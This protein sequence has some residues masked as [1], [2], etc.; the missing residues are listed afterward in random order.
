MGDS[1]DTSQS[2][3]DSS[4]LV[5]P[6]NEVSN[7][8][9]VSEKREVLVASLAI[10]RIFRATRELRRRRLRELQGQSLSDVAAGS[11]VDNHSKG[12]CA[13]DVKSID[14]TC[15]KRR[16]K[17]PAVNLG[18]LVEC[19]WLAEGKE[20][21]KQRFGMYLVLILLYYLLIAM[22][23]VPSDVYSTRQAHL[24]LVESV[25]TTSGSSVYDVTTYEDIGD[26][27]GSF[28]ERTYVSYYDQQNEDID[29]DIAIELDFYSFFCHN[30]WRADYL[31]SSK[32]IPSTYWEHLKYLY[33]EHGLNITESQYD[34]STPE[35]KE[36][37]ALELYNEIVYVND[38]WVQILESF[39][40]YRC[41]YGYNSRADDVSG[42]LLSYNRVLG[43]LIVYQER[44]QK[45]DGCGSEYDELYPECYANA[46]S[47]EPFYGFIS[48]QTYDWME[49]YGGGY[50]WGFNLDYLVMDS[51]RQI[52]E[53]EFVLLDGWLHR[54]TKVV[55]TFLVTF[56]PNVDLYLVATNRFEISLGGNIDV[57]V[58]V[59]AMQVSGIPDD[60]GYVALMVFT[61]FAMMYLV[62]TIV[63]SI[64]SKFNKFSNWREGLL[65]LLQ[66]FWIYLDVSVIVM[67]IM[68]IYVYIDLSAARSLVDLPSKALNTPDEVAGFINEISDIFRVR[69][70]EH[71]LRIAHAIL[72]LVLIARLFHY[73]E[74][75]ARLNFL[76]RT[77]KSC[78]SEL[79]YFLVI[80]LTI[81]LAYSCAANATWGHVIAEFSTLYSSMNVMC[82]MLA[83]FAEVPIDDMRDSTPL[84]AD[85]FV[86]SYTFF[87]VFIL[88]NIL[89]S[90]VLDGYARARDD[91]AKREEA[92][93]NKLRKKL[94]LADAM[95]LMKITSKQHWS[96]VFFVFITGS[97]T[98]RA[99]RLMFLGTA[100]ETSLDKC[101]Q[102]AQQDADKICL[103]RK[104]FLIA[105]TPALDHKASSI[106]FD[107][108][109]ESIL[110]SD[111]VLSD[112][113]RCNLTTFTF[114][115]YS[116]IMSFAE[117][118]FLCF[119][120]VVVKCRSL[121]RHALKRMNDI[122]CGTKLKKSDLN[123]ELREHETERSV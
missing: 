112:D 30:P 20:T 115:E 52:S 118:T 4:T 99:Q 74:F 50:Y 110:E 55:E 36:E 5:S 37:L 106:L 102:L 100:L 42:V 119:A 29:V 94:A 82:S 60:G 32:S 49:E 80:F 6:S 11:G 78:R 92:R 13:S 17:V 93:A 65:V 105:C 114:P 34:M 109:S 38:T 120:A 73:F 83:E 81:L 35:E 27:I 12:T 23:Q 66:D 101:V 91:I 121:W 48:N 19:I 39:G 104:T 47:H 24:N 41:E 67:V 28:F 21:L 33:L 108:F 56:N 79:A 98:P 88:F 89:I 63:R 71:F 85:I 14:R 90:I 45:T 117:N 113:P 57:Y 77:I 111:V 107:V 103:D 75:S 96:K 54:S 43:G 40:T 53:W 26:W 44:R 10:Q 8:N 7:S 123:V 16:K 18:I 84:F 122:R 62:S 97:F 1:I 46:N 68:L 22:S 61:S 116:T 86:W 64:C 25:E 95:A 72:M 87:I 70:S 31:L 3:R 9:H 59:D 2:I 76:L 15:T 69:D 51:E 58:N